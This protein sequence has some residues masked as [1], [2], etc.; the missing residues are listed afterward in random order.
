M[1]GPWV[2]GSGLSHGWGEANG[3]PD[4]QRLAEARQAQGTGG[5]CVAPRPSPGP[6]SL[7]PIVREIRCEAAQLPSEAAEP[8]A[9]G[10][11]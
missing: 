4:A 10:V 11:S 9:L 1:T 7:P 8:V 6:G 3:S 2:S 5:P